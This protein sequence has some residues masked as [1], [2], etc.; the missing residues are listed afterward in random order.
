MHSKRNEHLALPLHVLY[1]GLY[2]VPRPMAVPGRPRTLNCNGMEWNRIQYMAVLFEAI[3]AGPPHRQQSQPEL[4]LPIRR[5]TALNCL[6][7]SRATEQPATP[8]AL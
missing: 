7:H 4:L 2:S 8:G 5:G 1:C 3:L 6:Q